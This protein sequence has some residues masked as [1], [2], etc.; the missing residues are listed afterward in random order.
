ML[1][2]YRADILPDVFAG[3]C[4]LSDK[5]KEQMTRM[6]NFFCGLHF[7][8]ALAD[9]AEATLKLWES[10]NLD[11]QRTNATSGIQRLIR[12]ACKLSITGGL[13][14]LDVL[15]IFVLISEKK[16]YIKFFLH[17]SVETDLTFFYDAAGVFY[18]KSHME[19]NLKFHHGPLNRLL[20]AV[21]SDL[22]VPKYI[23]G[24]KALCIIDKIVTGPLWRHLVHSGGTI[25]EMSST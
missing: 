19:D 21:L 22:S 8:V 20:Q 5:E 3:W 18:L 24:C 13:S 23:A 6:N 12:T 10:V 14:K 2:E 16:E 4:E 9:A 7:L 17:N 11:D 15:H 1:S 25:L